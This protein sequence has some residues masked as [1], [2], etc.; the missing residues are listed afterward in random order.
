MTKLSASLLATAIMLTGTHAI[1]DDMQKDQN[2]E[3]MMKDCMSRMAAKGDGSTKDQMHTA[4]M[5]EMKNGM[6]MGKGKGMDNM[7]K[8]KQ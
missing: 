7:N 4:C 1:A 6:G 8:P 2:Q 3:Q 5:A